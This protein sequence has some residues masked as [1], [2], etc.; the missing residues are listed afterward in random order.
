LYGA[1]RAGF[2][3]I[4]VPIQILLMPASS[5]L[6]EFDHAYAVGRAIEL[7]LELAPRFNFPHLLRKQFQVLSRPIRRSVDARR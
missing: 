1:G 7:A 5:K 6:L 3:E 2:S 4:E